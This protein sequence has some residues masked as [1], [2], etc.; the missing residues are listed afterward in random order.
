MIIASSIRQVSK[1][2]QAHQVHAEKHATYQMFIE[3]W[4]KLIRQGC[5]S[6]D[7]RPNLLSRELQNLDRLLGLYGKPNGIKAHTALQASTWESRRKIQ[8]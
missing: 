3:L 8:M 2:D 6:E 1:Q 4:E 7:R 5:G